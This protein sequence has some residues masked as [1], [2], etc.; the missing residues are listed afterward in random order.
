MKALCIALVAF[1]IIPSASSAFPHPKLPK[2]G[3]LTIEEAEQYAILFSRWFDQLDKEDFPVIDDVNDI[4]QWTEEIVPF[5]SYEEVTDTEKDGGYFG[6]KYPPSATFEYYNDDVRHLH[7]LGTT[8]CM[9]DAVV[10]NAR[11]SNE[12]S[13][14]YAMPEELLVLIHELAHAQGVCFD[15]GTRLNSEVSAQLIALEVAAAMVNKGNKE[16][17]GPLVAE[18]K[19]MALSSVWSISIRQNNEDEFWSFLPTVEKDP[20]ELAQWHKS[21]RHWKSDPDKLNEILHDY[22]EVPLYEISHAF[23]KDCMYFDIGIDKQANLVYTPVYP[24][25]PCIN[26]VLLPVNW[27][28]FHKPL[29]VDDLAYVFEHGQEFVEAL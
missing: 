24:V 8:D 1:I 5:F 4:T 16:A 22:S 14:I 12:H 3:T 10:L 27:D 18:L 11:F 7:V 23:E 9:S 26:G 13:A 28:V 29:Y 6:Y 20:F 15:S 19:H 21:Q 25:E 2:E 17:F